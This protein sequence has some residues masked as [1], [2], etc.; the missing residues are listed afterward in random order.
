MSPIS[1]LLDPRVRVSLLRTPA[2]RLVI[3]PRPPFH[4]VSIRGQNCNRYEFALTTLIFFLERIPLNE[5]LLFKSARLSIQA[6]L[7]ENR[8]LQII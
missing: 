4:H 8:P 5:I 6:Y 7:H 2:Q 1:A 3:A